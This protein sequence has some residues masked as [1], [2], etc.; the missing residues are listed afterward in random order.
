MMR[1]YK[2]IKIVFL[3]LIIGIGCSELFFRIWYRE[4][5]KN[6]E[7]PLI[8]QPDSLYGYRHIPSSEGYISKPGIGKRHIKINSKGFY[9][10]EFSTEKKADVARIMIVGASFATGI[11][12]DGEKNY[13]VQLQERFDQAKKKVEIINCSMDGQGRGLANLQL[14]TAELSG[15][16]PDLILLEMSFPISL[17]VMQRDIYKN[18]LLTYTNDSTKIKAKNLVDELEG[19]TFFKTLYDL[20]YTY[21][22]VCRETINKNSFS[23]EAALMRAYRDKT[24]RASEMEEFY[25][26][27]KKS[28][29]LLKSTQE[30]LAKNGSNLQVVSYY[31]EK[32]NL[33]SYLNENGIHTLFLNLEFKPEDISLPDSHINERGH[34]LIATALYDSLA[35]DHFSLLSH[36]SNQL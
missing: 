14:L 36:K 25:L 23:R 9:S 17:G 11:Y 16:K 12:M 4:E 18:Y 32:N 35:H 19:K 5:L 10:P 8:F 21:R 30:Q 33:Q 15:Y 26:T 28:V 34:A 31:T 1:S 20:S 24:S 2:F 6:Q 29:E 3:V 13:A 27:S 7:P 22:A